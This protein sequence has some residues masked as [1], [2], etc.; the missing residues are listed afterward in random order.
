MLCGLCNVHI[1]AADAERCKNEVLSVIGGPTML[2]SVSFQIAA[3][4]FLLPIFSFLVHELRRA[5]RATTAGC[6]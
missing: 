2:S 3:D 6:K 4:F 1:T 5:E